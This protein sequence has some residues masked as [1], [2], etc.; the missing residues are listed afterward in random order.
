[1]HKYAPVRCNS[2]IGHARFAQVR[3]EGRLA[4]PFPAYKMMYVHVHLYVWICI[5]AIFAQV[6][7]EDRLALPFPAYTMITSALFHACMHQY[8]L[9]LSLSL[10]LSGKHIYTHKPAS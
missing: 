9:S 5:H 10:S 1:M 3:R 6:R 2:G 4:L 7:R 8:S